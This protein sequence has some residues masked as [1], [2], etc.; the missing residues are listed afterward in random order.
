MNEIIPVLLD[1]LC[2]CNE[3]FYTRVERFRGL[4]IRN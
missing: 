2:R 3:C 4:R 1:F